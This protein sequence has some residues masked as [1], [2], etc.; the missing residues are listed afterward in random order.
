VI[1]VS[2]IY[3]LLIND[4]LNILSKKKSVEDDMTP[5]AP[6]DKRGI[7]VSLQRSPSIRDAPHMHNPHHREPHQHAAHKE[8]HTHTHIRTP[9]RSPTHVTCI[10]HTTESSHQYTHPTHTHPTHMHHRYIS[11]NAQ[12]TTHAPPQTRTLTQ[13]NTTR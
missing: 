1:P 12:R 3:L 8:M 10:T 4:F 5:D 2:T 9:Q 7:Q 13:M 6:V 11:I